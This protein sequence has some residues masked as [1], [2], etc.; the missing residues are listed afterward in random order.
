MKNCYLNSD[1]LQLLRKNKIRERSIFVLGSAF[2]GV[3]QIFEGLRFQ[4]CVFG[5]LPPIFRNAFVLGSAF[6]SKPFLV[7][8]LSLGV[9]VFARTC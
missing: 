7:R 6:K 8:S 3:T 4:V 1:E 5:F 2:S 9:F